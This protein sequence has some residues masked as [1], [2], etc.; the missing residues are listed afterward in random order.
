MYYR[1]TFILRWILILCILSLLLPMSIQAGT[2]KD[3]WDIGM[4]IYQL[5]KDADEENRR[6]RENKSEPKRLKVYYEWTKRFAIIGPHGVGHYAFSKDYDAWWHMIAIYIENR[7]DKP[8]HIDP[9]SF[10]LYLSSKYNETKNS[11]SFLP[12]R[13][14][15]EYQK[16][17]L[18]DDWI[19]PGQDMSGCLIFHIPATLRDGTASNKKWH[20]L[21]YSRGVACQVNYRLSY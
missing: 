9:D 18:A 21:R 8:I 14:G 15:L 1:R 2:V 16:C 12:T 6:R 7:C 3:L 11:P 10:R 19:K 20:V 17:R 13:Q 5:R 4:D